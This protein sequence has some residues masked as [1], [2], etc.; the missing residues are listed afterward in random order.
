MIVDTSSYKRNKNGNGICSRSRIIVSCDGCGK[1]WGTQYSNYK[2]KKN[3]KDYCQSCKNKLGICGMKGRKHSIETV[4]EFEKSREGEGNGFYGKKHS[5]TMKNKSSNIRK[6]ILWRSPLS[7]EKKKEISIKV[8]QEWDNMPDEDREYKL[9]GLSESRKRLQKNG[10]RYS[11]LHNYVKYEMNKIG[12]NSFKSEQYFK[13]YFVDEL[14]KIKMIA[15]EING[16][17]WHA[18]PQKYKENDIISYPYGKKKA[19]EIWNRDEKKIKKLQ[20]G[21]YRVII[22]WESDINKNNYLHIL[23][24]LL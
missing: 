11:G 24:G 10:G 13:G 2:N 12:L 15:V 8:K 9:R 23:E 21:G 1:E 22:L 5:L 16:D 6:G 17:Y 19:H 20:E 14:S 18:N 4:K 3:I 7:K